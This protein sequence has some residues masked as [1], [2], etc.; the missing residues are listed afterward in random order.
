MFFANAISRFEDQV[1]R[2]PE[3]ELMDDREQAEAYANADFE[4]AHRRF[5]TTFNELFR[6]P[7]LDGYILDLGC[8]PGDITFRFARAFPGATVHGVDGSEAM[9]QCGREV[10]AEDAEL[11]G[12][13]TLIHGL[14]PGAVL[15]RPS[16]DAIISNSLLHHL[17]D[18][19]VL[20]KAV[21]NF[22]GPGAPVFIMDLKRPGSVEKAQS[23][24]TEYS[25]DEPEVLR[26][27][28][29]NS[30]LAA[31]TRTEIEEQ[32]EESGLGHLTVR[33][34]SDRHVVISGYR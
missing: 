3:P 15:P 1:Q 25:G 6:E 2:I 28:F 4:D 18:P 34:I 9:L 27:D 29:Y 8:G 16:Y 13:V 19:T 24:V 12:R 26:Q 32:L 23:L 30:L 31:F 20:W 21:S 10:L 33:E 22:S 11:Q 14:L 5:V 17:H 7:A